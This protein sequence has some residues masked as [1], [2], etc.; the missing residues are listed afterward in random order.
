MIL[1]T[2]IVILQF[3]IVMWQ[4]GGEKKR[5]KKS[6]SVKSKPVEDSTHDSA[7]KLDFYVNEPPKNEDKC[8]K[9]KWKSGMFATTS[10]DSHY[11]GD[12]V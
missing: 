12:V 4:L 10:K 2:N 3:E 1:K 9:N 11:H 6:S 8:P 7:D 5:K